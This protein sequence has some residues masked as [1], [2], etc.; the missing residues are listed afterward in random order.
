MS[1]VLFLAVIATGSAFAAQDG[2]S[3]QTLEVFP[4]EL[5]LE[6]GRDARRLLV[7]GVTD[8][9]LRYDLS[10]SASL[11]PADAT[12]R[13]DADG[14]VVPQSAGDCTLVVSAAGLEARVSVHVHSAEAPPVDF[15][16]DVNPI[17]SKVGCNQGTCHGS[18]KG[19][20]GFKLSLR[21]YDALYDYR[22]LIDDVAGR[23]FNRSQPGQSLMLR[24][25]TQG[26]HAQ[27]SDHSV[28][29]PGETTAPGPA[30]DAAA[31]R[32]RTL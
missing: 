22:A 6:N 29:V 15:R 11:T 9:G 32:H 8:N 5:K 16:N 21:G 13:I 30:R 23:R 10:H 2:P 14:F 12:V 17:L 18:Q 1:R 7:T 24:K 25:T 26:V 31:D 28:R 27:S 4:T 3:F 20:N 19:Q